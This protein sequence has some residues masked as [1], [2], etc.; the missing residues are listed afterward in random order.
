MALEH[1]ISALLQDEK[2]PRISDVVCV[3]VTVKK[4]VEATTASQAGT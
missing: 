4:D 1:G 3:V 2:G